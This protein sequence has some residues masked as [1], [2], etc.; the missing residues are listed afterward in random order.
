MYSEHICIYD[1]KISINITLI[2]SRVPSNF[3]WEW[4]QLYT[5][6][7]CRRLLSRRW[8]NKISRF[9]LKKTP[10]AHGEK[11]L[12]SDKKTPTFAPA[13]SRSRRAVFSGQE[14]VAQPSA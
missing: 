3:D 13:D 12:D 2:D 7:R 9:Q 8:E 11:M 6:R 4:A 5:A 10:V 1:I 14:D